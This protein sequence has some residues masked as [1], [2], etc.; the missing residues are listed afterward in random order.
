MSK[1]VDKIKF[2]FIFF[3]SLYLYQKKLKFSC[4]Y[5]L[6]QVKLIIKNG[7]V[8]KMVFFINHLVLC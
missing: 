3:N 8:L 7:Q 2:I 5:N 1:F 4:I 6:P